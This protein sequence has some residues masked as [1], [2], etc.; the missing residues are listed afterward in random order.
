MNLLEKSDQEILEIAEPMWD[1]LFESSNKRLPRFYKA[2]FKR[3]V[4]GRQ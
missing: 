1:D 3:D 4:N 2:L